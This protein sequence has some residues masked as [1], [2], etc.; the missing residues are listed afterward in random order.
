MSTAACL[1]H[2]G[3]PPETASSVRAE[4]Q[5]QS[6][7][8]ERLV[9]AHRPCC[10]QAHPS[11]ISGSQCQPWRTQGPRPPCPTTCPGGPGSPNSWA[12]WGPY[13]DS[14]GEGTVLP[15]SQATRCHWLRDG[16]RGFF[17]GSCTLRPGGKGSAQAHSLGEFPALDLTHRALHLLPTLH[18]SNL[19][20]A[21]PISSQL[22]WSPGQASK[23]PGLCSLLSLC[24]ECRSPDMPYN[25]LS[26]PRL[27][28]S[29]TSPEH[30]N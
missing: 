9:G 15:S 16:A 14:S 11:S 20:S 21:V 24:L 2:L 12:A 17:S 5:S 28:S 1:H 23:V 13:W 18:P 29:F 26:P 7:G 4:W 30:P 19:L 27:C 10:L 8:K 3:H 22:H 6:P 25:K